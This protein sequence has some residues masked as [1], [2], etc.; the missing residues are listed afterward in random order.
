MEVQI[1]FCCE[2]NSLAFDFWATPIAAHW[3]MQMNL[4]K[5]FIKK[6]TPSRMS[7]PL[8]LGFG[9]TISVHFVGI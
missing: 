8:R 9:Q 7:R 5:Q 1:C 4:P 6:C 2:G 3:E